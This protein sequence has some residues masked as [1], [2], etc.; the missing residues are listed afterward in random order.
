[1]VDLSIKMANED[2]IAR[3]LSRIESW[4]GIMELDRKEWNNSN[5]EKVWRIDLP[6]YIGGNG[7]MELYPAIHHWERWLRVAIS[8]GEV[9]WLGPPGHT[10][11]GERGIISA[12]S[13][14][15]YEMNDIGKRIPGRDIMGF[16]WRVGAVAPQGRTHVKAVGDYYV[17]KDDII[18]ELLGWEEIIAAAADHPQCWGHGLWDKARPGW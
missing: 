13:R 11:I 12:H 10:P 14:Y 18:H 8:F 5:V 7:I 17:K 2:G 6:P 4:Y 1:M 3:A 15:E 16:K 9:R